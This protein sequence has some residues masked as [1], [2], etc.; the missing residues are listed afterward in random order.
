MW[1]LSEKMKLKKLNQLHNKINLNKLFPNYFN[2]NIFRGVI[3]LLII[4]TIYVYVSEGYTLKFVYAE[5]PEDSLR[6][7]NNPFYICPVSG[8]YNIYNYERDDCIINETIPKEV[9]PLC[10]AGACN[11]EYLK[12]GEIIGNKP[13]FFVLNYNLICLLLVGMAFLTNHL[14]YKYRVTYNDY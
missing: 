14:Y 5:C 2:K 10:N 3:I 12:P 1:G 4:F 13:S 8:E 7:C 9:R 6:D 11:N